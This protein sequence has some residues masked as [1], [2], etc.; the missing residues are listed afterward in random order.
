MPVLHGQHEAMIESDVARLAAVCVSVVGL[1][2]VAGTSPTFYALVLRVLS[3]EGGGREDQGRRP[4]AL[5]LAGYATGK[6]G[7]AHV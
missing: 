7:R 5:L 2:L 1:G 3:H 6:F 4:L